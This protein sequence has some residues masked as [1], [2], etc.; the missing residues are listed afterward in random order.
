MFQGSGVALVTPMQHDGSIDKK[1]LHDLV[2]WHIASQTKGLIIA[3]TTGEG[4]TLTEDEQFDLL[5]TVV[6]QVAKRIPVIAGTGSNSTQHTIDLTL[7]A[8]K[9]G[10]DAA[11]VV[12]PYYN[13]P[14]QKGLIEHFKLVAQKCPI[15]I[16]LYNVPGRTACDMLPQTIEKLAPISNIIGIKEATGK[17]DRMTEILKRCGE[18][19]AVYSGDDFT[20]L[21]LMEKGAKGVISVTANVAPKEMSQMCEAALTGH[22]NEAKKINEKLIPLHKNLFLEANPIPVK[23]VLHEMGRMPAGIRLPLTMLDSTYHSALKEAMKSAS[24]G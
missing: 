10:A 8:K 4:A 2:E 11:L 17:I 24:I 14:T 3:G 1:S 20:S 12:T 9:A 6:K 16:I 18:K 7:N 15:P 19:F 23:W 21:E 5:Q 13:K 22:F